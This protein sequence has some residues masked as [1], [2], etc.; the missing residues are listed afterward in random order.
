MRREEGGLTDL[1][2]NVPG[3]TGGLV[4]SPAHCGPFLVAVL[5]N[6]GAADLQRLV[7]GLA[8]VLDHANLLEVLLALLLLVGLEGRD[9]AGVAPLVVAVVA[10]D[11]L[12]KLSLL[13]HHDL[14]S[15]T[16]GV[17]G[18]GRKTRE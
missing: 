13:R 15:T 17:G 18:E 12:V 1:V 7:V 16:S 5:H 3:G 9:V 11:D 2:F 14:H 10:G 6:L 8:L 4:D